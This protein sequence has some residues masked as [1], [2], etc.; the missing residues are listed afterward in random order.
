MGLKRRQLKHIKQKHVNMTGL[1]SMT[2]SKVPV[3]FRKRLN[4]QLTLK[5][6][7]RHA[8][9]NLHSNHLKTKRK[10]NVH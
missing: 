10:T 4:I 8:K 6:S 1:V 7:S 9:Y 2:C 3:W 5:F